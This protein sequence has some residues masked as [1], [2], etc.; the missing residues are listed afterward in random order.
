MR[1][2]PTE[3]RAAR[4]SQ[5]P[6]KKP[7]T[8]GDAAAYLPGIGAEARAT[9]NRSALASWQYR[10]PRPDGP[11]GELS[12]RVLG[13][14]SKR[15]DASLALRQQFFQAE[16]LELIQVPDDAFAKHVAHQRRVAMRPA[17]GLG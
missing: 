8:G 5:V 1:A 7:G 16:H 6:R 3:R 10:E 9:W 4:T 13:E 11:G 15:R 17:E 2:A 14:H 12:R